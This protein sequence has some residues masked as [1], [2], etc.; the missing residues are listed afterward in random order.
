[1]ICGSTAR[2]DA[3]SGEPSFFNRI[4]KSLTA[5]AKLCGSALLI[6]S[7][8]GCGSGHLSLLP[9][10]P[11]ARDGDATLTVIVTTSG[12]DQ[13]PRGSSVVITLA[14]ISNGLGDPLPIAGD[15]V[16]ISQADQDVHISL[17]ADR[18]QINKCREP[19]Q[20]GVYVRVVD[21]GRVVLGNGSPVPY[22]AGQKLLR[23]TVTL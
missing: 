1:M 10:A 15:T 18:V 12:R 23:V 9:E 16:Q 3:R 11:G 21:N 22:R 5:A 17:P 2:L 4:F 19:D 20:C 13:L 7:L 6:A 8:Q 14:D